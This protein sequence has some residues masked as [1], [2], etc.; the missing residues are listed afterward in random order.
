MSLLFE[1]SNA[2]LMVSNP[3]PITLEKLDRMRKINTIFFFGGS[4][5]ENKFPASLVGAEWRGDDQ[6]ACE[7]VKF[8]ASQVHF[9][10]FPLSWN[11]SRSPDMSIV[12]VESFK[13]SLL[14]E[15]PQSLPLKKW[16]TSKT[17]MMREYWGRVT[18]GKFRR[19]KVWRCLDLIPFN[20]RLCY[21][22]F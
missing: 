19:I 22:C 6:P 5:R 17:R 4:W 10:S 21:I 12:V 14:F 3:H 11:P 2:S 15:S 1:F 18:Q 20:K 16:I 7:Y 8:W 13:R 9:E